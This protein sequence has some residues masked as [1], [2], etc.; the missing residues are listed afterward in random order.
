MHSNL[1]ETVQ[2]VSRAETYALVICLRNV[3]ISSIVDFVS[4]NLPLVRVYN[5]GR[6]AAANSA[7]C[8][9]FEEI[10]KHIDNK[11]LTVSVRWVPSHLG[12]DDERPACMSL[13]DW[14]GNDRADN[15]ASEAA[16]PVQLPNRVAFPFLFMAKRIYQIQSR[17]VVIISNLPHRKKF[18]I[19]KISLVKE[20]VVRTPLD[21][22]VIQSA[23]NICNNGKRLKC[24]DCLNSFRHDDPSCKAWLTAPCVK[25]LEDTNVPVPI[26][27][28]FH[29]GNRN[30]HVS[31]DI[32]SF[33]AFIYCKKCGSYAGKKLVYLANQCQPPTTAGQR[34]L[35]S[36][37]A[38]ELPPG[39]DHWPDLD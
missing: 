16:K 36:I 24:R 3:R 28:T 31:H 29:I 26:Q 20:K 2:T 14:H 25:P 33:R 30:T 38:K 13:K 23:H 1:P 19:D 9:L 12:I 22:M 34:V 39:V 35:D 32:H 7:N 15:M 4:D 18:D 27:D 21:E 8:D 17:L 6:L 5:N 37:S 10:Y 11:Q